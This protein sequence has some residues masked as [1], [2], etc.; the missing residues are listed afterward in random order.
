MTD[1]EKIII[2]LFIL[3]ADGFDE[4]DRI[5]SIIVVY[6]ALGAKECESLFS[7]SVDTFVVHTHIYISI[8]TA[9]YSMITNL[10]ICI[11]YLSMRLLHITS[12]FRDDSAKPVFLIL[13]FKQRTGRNQED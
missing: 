3:T 2:V 11:L 6:F 4:Q 1:D 10:I 12:P 5:T 7:M 13:Q 9:D 8:R